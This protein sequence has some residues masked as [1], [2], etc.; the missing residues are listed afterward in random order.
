MSE[1]RDGA[2][3]VLPAEYLMKRRPF[4]A[5]RSTFGVWNIA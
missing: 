3:T 5:R 4:R 1:P 2:Q